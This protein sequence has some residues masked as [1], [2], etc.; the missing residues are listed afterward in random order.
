MIPASAPPCLTAM[1]RVRFP[2]TSATKFNPNTFLAKT[3]AK[4]DEQCRLV[5]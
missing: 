4:S 2:Q 5:S 3:G 1:S